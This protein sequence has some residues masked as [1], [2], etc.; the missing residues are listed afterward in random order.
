MAWRLRFDIRQAG[1]QILIVLGLLFALNGAF[2][3]LAVRPAVAEYRTL[4]VTNKPLFD[5]LEERRQK[6]LGREAFLAAVKQAEADLL[7]LRDEVLS[8]REERMVE[9]QAEVEQLAR[10]FGINLD[11][12]TYKNQR[13]EDE[14]LD[15]IEIVVPLE[16]GYAN[17]RRF[18]QAVES[19]DKFLVVERVG[20]VRGKEGGQLLQL[21]ITMATYFNL[22]AAPAAEPVEVERQ[23]EGER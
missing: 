9:V 4:T 5:R 8:T 6:V 17:L 18:L 3:A 22:S 15:R 2:Y 11:S 23:H 21:N 13:L 14:Q 12:V 20:L 1:R 7:K 10:Q 16:G 19:S